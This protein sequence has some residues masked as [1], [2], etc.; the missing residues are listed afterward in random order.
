MVRGKKEKMNL[1]EWSKNY[2]KFKD[3][4]KRQIKTIEEIEKGLLVH[5]K[6]ENKNY[7]IYEK[8]KNNLIINKKIK[9]KVFLITLNTKENVKEL[10][11]NWALVENEDLTIIF[12]N[13]KTNESWM[14]HPKTHSKITEKKLI[15]QGLISL[16]ESITR[17]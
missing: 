3:C 12:A 7:F 10:A 16:H 17:S 5:E 6:K 4:F 13:I 8:L 1:T 14:V 9:N 2:I 15:K 11:D